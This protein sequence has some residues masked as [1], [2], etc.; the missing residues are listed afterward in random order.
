MDTGLPTPA[1]EDSDDKDV[2]PKVVR[3][4]CTRDRRKRCPQA[5]AVLGKVRV[6]KTKP[7]K[8]NAQT[9]K[10]TTTECNP[11]IQDSNAIAQSSIPQA[12]KRRKTKFQRTKEET[13]ICQLRPQRVSKAERFADASAKSMSGTQPRG[14]RQTRSSERT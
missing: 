4:T 11:A 5:S 7:K 3:R 12:S 9:H 10:P 14:A 1:E 2:A 6:A 8:W 13:P